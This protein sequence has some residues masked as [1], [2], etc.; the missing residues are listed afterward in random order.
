M[1]TVIFEEGELMDDVFATGR[2]TAVSTWEGVFF[3]RRS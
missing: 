1:G 2:A 3:L